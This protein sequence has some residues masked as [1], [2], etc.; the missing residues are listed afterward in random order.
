MTVKCGP[1]VYTYKDDQVG[2][3]G[4]VTA[5][6]V[7]DDFCIVKQIDGKAFKVSMKDVRRPDRTVKAR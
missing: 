7:V 4:V 5:V 6:N 2:A 3:A 1:Y